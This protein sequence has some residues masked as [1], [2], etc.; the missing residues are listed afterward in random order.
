MLKNNI[1]ILSII[2]ILFVNAAA[3]F[4]AAE[5]NSVTLSGSAVKFIL[6]MTGVAVS[7]LVIYLGLTIYNKFFANKSTTNI[8]TGEMSLKTPKTV[9][10]AIAFFIQKNKMN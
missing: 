5:N 3:V 9:K 4:A 7:S 10:D 1:K 6:A 2:Y 8:Y